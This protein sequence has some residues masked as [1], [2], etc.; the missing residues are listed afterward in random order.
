MPALVCRLLK[1][2]EP[3]TALI[4]PRTT[5]HFDGRAGSNTLVPLGGP[6]DVRD[7]GSGAL[8]VSVYNTH[9]MDDGSRV[10]VVLANVLASPDAPAVIM[11]R[12][13]V[14]GTTF[15]PLGWYEQGSGSPAVFSAALGEIGPIGVAVQPLLFWE[16]GPNEQTSGPAE[17]S[18]TAEIVRRERSVMTPRSFPGLALWLRADRFALELDGN[19]NVQSW[20]DLSGN[21]RH[22]MNQTAAERPGW[23]QGAMNAQPALFFNGGQ[24][25]VTPAFSMTTFTTIMVFSATTAGMVYE[26]SG[27]PP[28]SNVY[29][30]NNWT[31]LAQRGGVT[32]AKNMPANWATDGVIRIVRHEF[33]GTHASQRLAINGALQTLTNVVVN[34]PGTGPSAVLPVAIG[35]TQSAVLP[36][37]GQIGE[38]L[39]YSPK[40]SDAQVAL[41]ERQYL[42]PRYGL[43]VS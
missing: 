10:S 27:S 13:P 8:V 12:Q 42:G 2:R 16:Q 35:A 1:Q 5:F 29:S 20:T 30:S 25:L 33:E 23:L 15:H 21:G 34:D 18:L 39:I 24:L 26:H 7:T 40:L 32:S 17:I 31:M 3:M 41:L 4:I 36:I 22:A 11:S 28:A 43:I 6:I 14:A 38:L 37:S 9:D 19:E